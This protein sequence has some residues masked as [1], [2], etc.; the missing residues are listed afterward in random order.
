[1]AIFDAEAFDD[2]EQ[3]VFISDPSVSL[4]AIIAIHNTNLGPSLGGCRMWPYPTEA[5]ALHDVL[6]LSRGMT[7]KAAMAKV[8]LGGG[9]AVVIADAAKEKRPELLH[10]IGRWIDR[11]GGRYITGED[12][13]T[14]TFDMAEIKKETPNVS[15]LRKED[16]GYGDPAPMTALGVLQAIRAG[17]ERVLGVAE[18]NGVHVAVQGVGNVGRNLC[19]LLSAAGARLTVCDVN[20]ENLRAAA[21]FGA[22]T[23]SPDAIYDVEAEVFAPCA[24]GAILDDETIPRLRVKVVAGAANNQLA[25]D[26][27]GQSLKARG[28]VYLPDYVANGGGLICCSAEWYRHDPEQVV[29]KVESI[30][31]TCLEIL[32]RAVELDVPPNVA[33]DQ[34]AEQRFRGG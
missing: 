8:A 14:D 1:M 34:L 26:R 22:D 10:A 19:G 2:H 21:E 18:L 16:G 9:K 15:C 23:V 11:L 27:H 12:I 33:S 24:M 25:A 17:A 6:R 31:E 32:D 20:E 13:G 5:E 7:Y 28:I 29:A 4:K 30:H 3:V